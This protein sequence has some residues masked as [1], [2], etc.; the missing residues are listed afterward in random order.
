MFMPAC[1]E[2]LAGRSSEHAPSHY[3]H[4]NSTDCDLVMA[5]RLAMI[6]G[7]PDYFSDR[8]PRKDK[9]ISSKGFWREMED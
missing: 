4:T 7:A 2:Q 3:F 6:G 8:G 1:G 5:S 9:V